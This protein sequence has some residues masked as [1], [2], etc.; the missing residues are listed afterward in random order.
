M[1]PIRAA[2]MGRAGR[3]GRADVR[4]GRAAAC[5][6][7]PPLPA[8]AGRAGRR[9]PRARSGPA[10]GS[11]SGPRRPAVSAG[12]P[13]PRPASGAVGWRGAG[14]ALLPALP[15]PC[16]GAGVALGRGCCGSGA[17]RAAGAGDGDG[18]AGRPPARPLRMSRLG[19]SLAR[20]ARL[21]GASCSWDSVLGRT[22]LRLPWEQL[23]RAP[24]A[25]LW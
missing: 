10:P 11:D 22:H 4:A 20:R 12:R 7:P 14:A 18:R 16:A 25:E 2:A 23:L 6:R 19:D 8:R 1:R 13:R 21:C 3:G 9:D 5:S 17:A 24:A 15:P